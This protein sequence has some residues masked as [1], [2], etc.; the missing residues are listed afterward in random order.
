M[1]ILLLI[2][3]VT[4]IFISGAGLDT[5]LAQTSKPVLLPSGQINTMPAAKQL[6]TKSFSQKNNPQQL[7]ARLY[8]PSK[9]QGVVYSGLVTWQCN[10]TQ[11]LGTSS[12][13]VGKSACVPLVK[14]VGKVWYFGPVRTTYLRPTKAQPLLN[15]QQVLNAWKCNLE[16][17]MGSRARALNTA[18]LQK[19]IQARS[20]AITLG[21]QM[22]RDSNKEHDAILRN[23]R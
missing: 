12:F 19:E 15:N 2:I 11:C 21:T 1:R 23:I 3:G 16:A 18:D 9:V 5:V 6:S 22:M 4:T 10:G 13:G 20:E 14:Q 7:A 8:T 17:E